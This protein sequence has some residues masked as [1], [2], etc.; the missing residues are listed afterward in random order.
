MVPP[1]AGAGDQ[2][3]DNGESVDVTTA[4]GDGCE[5]VTDKEVA[6]NEMVGI[7]AFATIV[8][9]AAELIAEEQPDTVLVTTTVK[10][11]TPLPIGFWMVLLFNDPVPGAVQLYVTA[12]SEEVTDN[13]TVGDAHEIVYAEGLTDTVGLV[14][15]EGT[16]IFAVPVQPFTVLVITTE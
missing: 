7:A 14:V 12:G 8:A 10:T 15:L 1:L 2:E 9:V 13:C 6:D 11:P 16:V 5:Q 4:D 3:Y